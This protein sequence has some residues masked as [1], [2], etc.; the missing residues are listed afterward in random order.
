[1]AGAVHT[2]HY[3]HLADGP[4]HIERDE[5]LAGLPATGWQ[6]SCSF[7][8]EDA[9]YRKTLLGIDALTDAVRRFDDEWSSGSSGLG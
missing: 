3:Y 8:W 6:G 2:R 9:Q 7:N 4:E 1:M 5:Q